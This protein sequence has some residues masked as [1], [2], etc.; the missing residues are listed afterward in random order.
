MSLF[1]TPLSPWRARHL[2]SHSLLLC[3]VPVT[4]SSNIHRVPP[5]VST[6][7]TQEDYKGGE[8]MVP[9]LKEL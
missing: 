6:A 3:S 8:D 5:A 2:D 9:A 1:E 7:Q 4:H